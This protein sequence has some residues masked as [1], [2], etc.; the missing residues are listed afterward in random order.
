LLVDVEKGRELARNERKIGPSDPLT[1]ARQVAELGTNVLICGAISWPLEM[2]L[3]S[4]GVQVVSRICGPVEE[5]LKGY[6]RGQL[7]G[8]AFLMPG[9]QGR[10]RRFRARHGRGRATG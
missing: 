8:N 3:T 1:Q 5:V 9:C 4:A 7:R 2:A 6:L 10:R